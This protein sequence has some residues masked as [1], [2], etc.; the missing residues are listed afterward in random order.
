[1]SGKSSE[2]LEIEFTGDGVDDFDYLVKIKDFNMS[3]SPMSKSH[4]EELADD[5]IEAGEYLKRYVAGEE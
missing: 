4:V 5:L 1:M 2:L 3:F